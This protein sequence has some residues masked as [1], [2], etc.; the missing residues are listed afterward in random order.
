MGFAAEG[1]EYTV[2]VDVDYSG[3]SQK[4]EEQ[5]AMQEIFDR[6]VY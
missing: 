4:K 5:D 3:R 2:R 1:T 6:C